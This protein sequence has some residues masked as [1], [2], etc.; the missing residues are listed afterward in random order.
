MDGPLRTQTLE[1]RY[2]E[3]RVASFA[4]GNRKRQNSCTKLTLYHPITF[5]IDNSLVALE[6]FKT[7]NNGISWNEC[8]IIL[9]IN[10]WLVEGGV[11]LD[12][13][14]LIGQ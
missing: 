9:F 12:V 6:T 14:K 7:S 2:L 3:F 5:D 1:V 11:G 4:S 10:C 8:A 13:C